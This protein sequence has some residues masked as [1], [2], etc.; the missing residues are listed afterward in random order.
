MQNKILLF[1]TAISILAILFFSS[2]P[3]DGISPINS[4]MQ[5]AKILGNQERADFARALHIKPFSFPRDHGPHPTFKHEW[6]YV[7]GNLQA[8]KTK[9]KFGFQW[10][11]FRIGLAPDTKPRSSAWASNQIYMGH[12]TISDAQAKKFYHWQKFSRPVLGMAGANAEP[13]RAWLHNWQLSHIAGPANKPSMELT[14]KVENAAID[15]TLK[16]LKPV[17]LQ[18]DRGLSQKSSQPGNASYYYSLP[19]L[20]SSGTLQIAGQSFTVSGL[21]WL[22]R[23][24]STSAL[25]DDQ[26]GWDWFSL[27]L[28]DGFDLIYYQIRTKTQHADLNSQ[29]AMIDPEG[30]KTTIRP[31]DMGITTIDHWESPHSKIIYPSGW[32]LTSSRHD[33]QLVVTPLLKD[34]EL[35]QT[36]VTYWE[37]AVKV[38]GVH[39]GKQ[40]SGSGYVELAGY[41]REKR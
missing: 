5:V 11:L 8:S 20:Q 39:A 19:R 12:L 6:W 23:E 3:T 41:G 33:L 14:A 25:A 24:W 26:A 1:I 28:E 34:Q 35:N 21:A 30:S 32:Q 22:D 7:T 18:G 10:T 17:V 16:P 27:H 13:F 4:T 29:G 9:R 36:V 37:G 2:L 38:E 40:V 31:Q 15:L